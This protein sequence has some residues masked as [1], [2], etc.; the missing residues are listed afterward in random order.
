MLPYPPSKEAAAVF[1][2][3]TSTTKGDVVGYS[4]ESD[5]TDA[6]ESDRTDGCVESD[7]IDETSDEEDADRKSI[8]SNDEDPKEKFLPATADGL[9]KRFKLWREFP[10]CGKH[11]HRNELV[12]ILD[13]LLRQ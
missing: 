1:T 11:K 5:D 7:G 8:S 6:D 3:S 4:D 12:F 2:S 9:W 13:E 10:R